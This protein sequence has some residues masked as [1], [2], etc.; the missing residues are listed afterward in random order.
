MRNNQEKVK[1]LST[2]LK[3]NAKVINSLDFKIFPTTRYQGSKRKLLPWL[4]ENIKSLNFKT[5]IDIFGGTASVSYLFKSMGKEVTFNDY[6]KSNYY[7]GKALI[8]NNHYLLTDPD[9]EFLLKRHKTITYGTFVQDTFQGIYFTD[10][11]NAWID[12]FLSNWDS[13]GN[14]YSKKIE[15]YKKA[16]AFSA[17]A[18]SALKKRP[19][20]LFHRANLYLRLNNVKRSFGNKTSWDGSFDKYFR[21]FSNENNNSVFNNDKKNKILNLRAS[22]INNNKYDLL[23]I[24][25]PYI[26]EHRSKAEYDYMRFY[27]FL[28]GA[29]D[30]KKWK[31]RINYNT[32]NLRIEDNKDNKWISKKD[33][34]EA[35][36]NLFDNFRQSTIVIS[37]KE[38]GIPTKRQLIYSLKRYK[39]KIISIPSIKY[40]YAL[41]KNNGF[42]K[43]YL[44]IGID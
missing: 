10:K 36:E 32:K 33:N 42:H 18:Q 8:E 35:F 1:T 28:E 5:A 15:Q 44:L 29:C 21:D 30:L 34:R 13:F 43:E 37:Y 23:Y 27:H 2:H 24:D 14:I 19:F 12:M 17:F 11:E 40:D 16:I 38:P 25:P 22:K 41:N 9:I 39:K 6:L 31:N 3:E 7:I 26:K 20:N 4:Y